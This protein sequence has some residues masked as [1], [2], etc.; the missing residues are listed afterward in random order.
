MFA[1]LLNPAYKFFES[2]LCFCKSGK[3]RASKR[4]KVGRMQHIL[5]VKFFRM[6]HIVL[7]VVLLPL[8]LLVALDYSSYVDAWQLSFW[9]YN[10]DYGYVGRG[11][12]GEVVSYFYDAPTFEILQPLIL[13]SEKVVIFLSIL[14][15]W[16][17]LVPR[18]WTL[19]Y[20]HQNKLLL[21][22]FAAVLMVLPGWKMFGVIAGFGDEWA[23]FFAMLAFISFLGRQPI[24]YVVFNIALYANHPQGAAYICL[25][26]VLVVHSIFRNPVYAR[27]WRRWAIALVVVFSSIA[28]LYSMV[29][30]ETE[31]L[32]YEQHKDEIARFLPDLNIDLVLLFADIT[33]VSS[34][35]MQFY[36][37]FFMVLVDKF[38]AVK[39][40]ITY[41]GWIAVYAV[42]FWFACANAGISSTTGFLIAGRPI[43]SRF[44]PYERLIMTAA[45][46]FCSFLM[47]LAA[48]DA[49][50]FFHIAFLMMAI[51]VAY[52]IWFSDGSHDSQEEFKSSKKKKNKKNRSTC[53]A[54]PI[55]AFLLIWAYVF[56][57]APIIV[58]GKLKDTCNLCQNTTYFLNKHPLGEWFSRTVYDFNAYKDITLRYDSENLYKH[59]LLRFPYNEDRFFSFENDRFLIS[60]TGQDKRMF[61]EDISI[62]GGG[63]PIIAELNYKGEVHPPVALKY[64]E[65]VIHPLHVDGNKVIWKFNDPGNR[66]VSFYHLDSISDKDYEI[67]DFSLS[68]GDR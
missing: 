68:I 47:M 54:S 11:L 20:S 33:D 2:L 15:L 5:S 56:A 62:K 9:F 10:Y 34:D 60:G 39:M 31:R 61:L 8:S 27:Y 35:I 67:I 38:F 57:G 14:M 21:M 30:V 29:S 36:F 59:V 44:I 37:D 18:I 1:N 32:I 7:G 53:F 24:L 12:R 6:A 52:F 51:V 19:K 66:F 16:S 23:F 26:A 48:G 65:Q 4:A 63:M 49:E 45:L 3:A 58:F 41:G 43:L 22:A 42:L 46:F 55:T 28:F 50:R 17:V 64:Y 13:L 25:L 40:T